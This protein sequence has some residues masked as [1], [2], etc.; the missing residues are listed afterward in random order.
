MKETAI[1]YCD[2]YFGT[3]DGKTANGLVRNSR[4]FDIVGVIDSTKVGIDAGECLVG[5]KN[6][7]PIFKSLIHALENLQSVPDQF[8]YGI[9]PSEAFLK[10]DERN[11]L[12]RAMELGMNIVNPLHEF[13][14]DDEEFIKLAKQFDVTILDVRKPVQK[15]DMHLFS[16]RVLHIETPVVAVLG[17]DSAIGKRTTSVLL[18]DALLERGLNVAFIATGQTGLIQGAKYG[19]AIDAIPSQFMTGEIENQIMKAY[20]NDNPDIIIV[21]GQGALSHPAYISS[22]GI[23]R[24]ARP[25]AVIIQHAPK[26]SHLG[27]FSYIEMPTV[28]SEI[29]LIENF[30]KAEVIAVTINHEN[31]SNEELMATISEYEEDLKLPTTDALKLGCDKL[32]KSIF[33]AYPELIGKQKKVLFN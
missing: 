5:E 19:V 17:T 13:F 14:T 30:S 29:D 21:E 20:E 3:M 33:D 23:I 22:C 11:L 15:K 1:V 9:A 26:R 28:K 25:G 7:I 2:N 31:M 10:I 16:G 18:E 27:D 32:I 12:F 24:G 8:I 4:K 6:G